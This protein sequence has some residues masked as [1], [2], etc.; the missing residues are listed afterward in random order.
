MSGRSSQAG[1]PAQEDTLPQAGMQAQAGMQGTGL[2]G[3]EEEF[4]PLLSAAYI[5]SRP[6]LY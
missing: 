1:T 5:H 3:L 4:R 2:R 6:M